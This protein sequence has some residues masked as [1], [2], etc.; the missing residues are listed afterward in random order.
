MSR[1]QKLAC[2]SAPWRALAARV[3][4]WALQHRDL[5]GD[6]LEIGCGSGAMAAAMLERH[7]AIRLTATD[8]DESMVRV[9]AER[10]AHFGDRAVVEHADAT[11]LA[12][13]DASFDVVVTF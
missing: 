1:V 13:A 8:Y 4:P 5:G 3:L 11:A 7:L 10:L 2:R 9:A 12:Y 6:V